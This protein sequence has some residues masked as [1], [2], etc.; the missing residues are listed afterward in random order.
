MSE[1]GRSSEL[2]WQT[3]NYVVRDRVEHFPTDGARCCIT[4]DSSWWAWQQEQL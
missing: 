2:T 3:N 4:L 1:R